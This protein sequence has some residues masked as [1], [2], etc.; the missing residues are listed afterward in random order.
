MNHP[1]KLLLIMSFMMLFTPLMFA[2]ATNVY[3]TPNGNAQGACTANPQAPA[4]FNNPANWG[5]GAG[6]IGPGTVVLLCGTF[7]NPSTQSL[8][9][10]G[11]GTSGK[12]ITL[13][14]DYANGANFTSPAWTTPPIQLNS[15]SYV[16]IDGGVP[17]GKDHGDDNWT[18][19]ATKQTGTGIIQ[20][21]GNGTL[22]ANQV[23]S[24]FI[25]GANGT[26][27]GGC[28]HD[29]EIRNLLLLNAYVKS[30]PDSSTAAGSQA[31]YLIGCGQNV[32]LHDLT[33]TYGHALAGLGANSSSATNWDIS[34]NVLAHGTWGAI[35]AVG[36]SPATPSNWR[37]H[38]NDINLFADWSDPSGIYHLDG[39]F[40]YGNSPTGYP[41][42][43]YIYNNYLHGTWGTGSQCPTGYMYL[44][45][46]LKD[47]YAF[48]NV[49]QVTGQYACNGDIALADEQSIYA[50][51]NTH[52]GVGGSTASGGADPA[53]NSASVTY[54]NNISDNIQAPITF[55]SDTMSVFS[56]F[57]HNDWFGYTGSWRVSSSWY[58]WSQWQSQTCGRAGCDA[59]GSSGDPKLSASFV[60]QSGSAAIGLGTNL[61]SI[62]NGQANPGLGALCYDKNGNP[63]PSSGA[64]DAGAINSGTTSTQSPNPPN[65]LTAVVQ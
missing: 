23:S 54:E 36:N 46:W 25:V 12:V 20:N 33:S 62:C 61:Y 55:A 63:R 24:N 45:G 15:Q 2:S 16:L 60:P 42:G 6:Q 58:S 7:S 40:V 65:G 27:T 41:D 4:W 52:V 49:I 26:F 39:I 13:L 31:M 3:I 9:F 1:R 14:F 43:V 51:N 22:L 28:G 30:G 38:D 57:D 8:T 29:I 50:Y 35:M 5:T 21:S 64:W 56:T 47:T 34:Y 10:Q 44:S 11:S 18:A 53:F 37:I 48:N 17:C 59:N 19:C 32:Y